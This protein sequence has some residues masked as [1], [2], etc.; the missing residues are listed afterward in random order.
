MTR[1]TTGLKRFGLSAHRSRRSARSETTA[2]HR[3]ATRTRGSMLPG[4]QRSLGNRCGMAGVGRVAAIKRSN[5]GDNGRAASLSG[6]TARAHQC[7][8]EVTA[9]HGL[10]SSLAIAL[11]LTAAIWIFGIVALLMGGDGRIVAA[12]FVVGAATALIEWSIAGKETARLEDNSAA[13]E[14]DNLT[15]D[16]R[17]ST[18]Q[19]R[20]VRRSP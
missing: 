20:R 14:D 8:S 7:L 19:V 2:V 6:L 16:A 18:P 9:M 15:P 10:P 12:A 4:L 5:T 13:P 1:N 17:A 3:P 11:R